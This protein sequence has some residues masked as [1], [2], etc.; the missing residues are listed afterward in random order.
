MKGDKKHIDD[1]FKDGLKDLELNDT[2]NVWDRVEMSVH[3]KKRKR[4]FGFWFWSIAGTVVGTFLILLAYWPA[5]TADV[6]PETAKKSV[7]ITISDQEASPNNSYSDNTQQTIPES[8]NYVSEFSVIMDES[9]LIPDLATDPKQTWHENG[10]D[11]KG[12]EGP[13]QN[14]PIEQ[15]GLNDTIE[16][17]VEPD[18]SENSIAK[19]D[20]TTETIDSGEMTKNVPDIQSVDSAI[21]TE[22]PGKFSV[23]SIGLAGGIVRPNQ[24]LE[25]MSGFEAY[26]SLKSGNEIPANGFAVGLRIGA[27]IPQ[28]RE[29]SRISVQTGLTVIDVR[30]NTPSINYVIRDSFPFLNPQGDTIAMIP[31]AP[32]DSMIRDQS[33]LQYR[34]VAVPINIGYVIGISDRLELEAMVGTHLNIITDIKGRTIDSRMELK[35]GKALNYR[36]YNIGFNSSLGVNYAA[37]NKLKINVSLN[38]AQ[39][40]P[41]LYKDDASGNARISTYGFTTGV[42]YEIR[43]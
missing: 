12:S 40:A 25:N 9:E 30:F 13:G 38:Y 39:F 18:L 42:Y 26:S 4:R 41:N 24:H 31:K 11:E 21:D 22:I 35:E 2:G 15:F 29:L 10:T 36:K 19:V 43:R 5:D 37:G 6:T 3:N 27:S 14:K 23:F 34:S 17:T 7:Q 20:S 32:V 28:K 16:K 33:R 8:G 1:L